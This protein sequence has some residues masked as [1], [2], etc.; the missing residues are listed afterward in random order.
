MQPARSSVRLL[1]AACVATVVAVACSIGKAPVAGGSERAMAAARSA[2]APAPAPVTPSDPTDRSRH[3]HQQHH[4][5]HRDHAGEPLVRSLLR[6]VPRRGRI[7]AGRAGSHRRVRPRPPGRDLSTALSRHEPV[8]CRRPPR[9]PRFDDRRERRT[10]GRIR[11]GAGAD[12]QRMRAPARCVPV[13]GGHAGPGRA[14]RHHGVSHRKRDPEL[15][16][17]CEALRA[18]GPHVRAGVFVDPSLAPVPRVG[19]VGDMSRP[20]RPDELSIG[21]GVPGEERSR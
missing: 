10:D 11:Q 17:V 15:L 14:A 12:R 1:A 3:R 5:C 16:G 13:P 6:H 9:P 20:R 8:R 7:P 2:A 18:A 4:P 19:V 21:S